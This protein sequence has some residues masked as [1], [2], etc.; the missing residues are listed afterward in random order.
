MLSDSVTTRWRRRAGQISVRLSGV[1]SW[2]KAL[3]AMC[4][5]GVCGHSWER[6]GKTVDSHGTA[7]SCIGDIGDIHERHR[8][9][10][11]LWRSFDDSS[12]A[13]AHVATSPGRLLLYCPSYRINDGLAEEATEGLLDATACPSPV[14]WLAY[15]IDELSIGKDGK[16]WAWGDFL[17]SWIPGRLCPLVDKG[18]G[19]DPV[20]CTLWADSQEAQRVPS[21]ARLSDALG[22]TSRFL[23]VPVG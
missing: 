10:E 23:G 2:N 15:W 6:A 16:E 1:S 4:H 21:I 11:S 20:D 8:F 3:A 9:A 12:A 18:R 17:I 22:D 19:V 14:V 5:H 7:C 13:L